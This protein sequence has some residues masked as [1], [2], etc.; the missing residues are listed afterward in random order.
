MGD[1]EGTGE[2]S[3]FPASLHQGA[4]L[5]T[6]IEKYLASHSYQTHTAG[7][8][9]CKSRSTASELLARKGGERGRHQHS[10][11]STRK[12]DPPPGL[13]QAG[14]GTE[15]WTVA[16]TTFQSPEPCFANSQSKQKAFSFI[17]RRRAE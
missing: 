8:E 1:P 2:S 17:G 5:G 7:V 9:V 15:K 4:L 12:G 13:L 6:L 3:A 10:Q 16:F 14:G 11:L